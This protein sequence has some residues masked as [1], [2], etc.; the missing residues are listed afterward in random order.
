M[1]VQAGLAR[2]KYAGGR[3]TLRELAAWCDVARD[4]SEAGIEGYSR[5]GLLNAAAELAALRPEG[6]HQ[7]TPGVMDAMFAICTPTPITVA[8]AAPA[9]AYAASVAPAEP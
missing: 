5:T 1:N 8:D 4:T 2:L 6:V 3:A 9:V 7:V